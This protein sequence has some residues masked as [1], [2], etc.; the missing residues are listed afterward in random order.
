VRVRGAGAWE[1][2]DRVL[3]SELRLREGQLQHTLALDDAGRPFADVLLACDQD[4]F[5]LIA[6]GPS[7]AELTGYLRR[8]RRRSRTSR[9]RTLA[10]RLRCSRWTGHTR[11]SCSR[12][13]RGRR[14][15]AAVPHVLSRSPRTLLSRRAHGE[16]GYGLLVP[17]ERAGDVQAELLERG[18]ALDGVAGTRE[19]IEHCALENAYFNVRREAARTRPRS[20]FSCSGASPTARILSGGRAHARPRRG[21]ARRLTTL[22][23]AAPLAEGDAVAL[24]ERPVER[25]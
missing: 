23:S 12:R 22:V 1:A 25:S 7:S 5:V 17:R 6:D 9:S 19:A 21:P 13:W 18:A 11:G 24:E 10:N 15:R 16:Y 3:T 2:L 4:A 20:S 14:G 8:T